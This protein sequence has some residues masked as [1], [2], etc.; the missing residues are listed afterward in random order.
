MG[1]GVS[2]IWL[3]APQT[4]AFVQ[5][6]TDT[7]PR[8]WGAAAVKTSGHLS[9]GL[10]SQNVFPPDTQGCL[11]N[12]KKPFVTRVLVTRPGHNPSSSSG[13]GGVRVG[14]GC[15]ELGLA[16][17]ALST[18][19][20]VT[21]RSRGWGKAEVGGGPGES[22]QQGQRG[23]RE[24]QVS[25]PETAGPANWSR[26][27]WGSWWPLASATTLLKA[28]DTEDLGECWKGRLKAHGRGGCGFPVV[29]GGAST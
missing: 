19:R 21:E 22:T 25:G 2:V 10:S 3:R 12:R 23:Q 1:P 9:S 14:E 13:F 16:T 20:R 27:A 26:A 8:G 17:S 4:L 6:L 7:L 11:G 5:I 24:K 28:I 15:G 29:P 18:P